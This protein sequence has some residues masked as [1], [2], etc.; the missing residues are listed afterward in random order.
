MLNRNFDKSHFIA[1]G[2]TTSDGRVVVGS[3]LSNTATNTLYICISVAPLTFQLLTGGSGAPTDESYVVLGAS[4]TL[5]NER[6][7]T[8][9]SGI[10]LTDNGAGSTIVVAATG[11]A[12]ADN[13]VLEW[14]G[15]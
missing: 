2:A 5:I 14:L 12:G 15:L 8:A 3:L 1:A 13:E 4:G 9:G 10:S 7:L 11:G 6:V